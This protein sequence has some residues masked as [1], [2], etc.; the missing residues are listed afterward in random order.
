MFRRNKTCLC[1]KLALFTFNI[2]CFNLARI[3]FYF[4]AFQH[5][6]CNPVIYNW[7]FLI[8]GCYI[9]VRTRLASSFA[10]CF[11]CNLR[12]F[13]VDMSNVSRWCNVS[14]S[15]PLERITR[16]NCNW[17]TYK[18]LWQFSSKFVDHLK[19]FIRFIMIDIAV[20]LMLISLLDHI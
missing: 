12:C 13:F 9:P 1:L 6:F 3:D 11:G 18:E 20:S 15:T 4:N 16:L 10:T 5:L 2:H 17:L 19:F 8:L 14:I 7:W